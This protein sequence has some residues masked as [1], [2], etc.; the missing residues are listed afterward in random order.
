MTFVQAVQAVRHRWWIPVLLVVVAVGAVYALSPVN[1]KQKPSYVASTIQL[2]NP[3]ANQQSSTVN[4][5]EAQLEVKVGA[6][7]AA[8]AKILKYQGSPVALAAI[9]QVTIN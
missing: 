6:V 9:P 8:A 1:T 4:L 7:P 2:V 3:A 5:P